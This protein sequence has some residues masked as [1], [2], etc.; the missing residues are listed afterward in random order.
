MTRSSPRTAFTGVPF[1]AMTVWLNPK[2]FC[3]AVL[4]RALLK[5]PQAQP[6]QSALVSV[7]GKLTTFTGTFES[8]VVSFPSSPP[9]FEPQ[10]FTAPPEVTAQA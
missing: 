7:H 3:L 9:E 10:H 5:A 4:K 6:K 1:G 2:G 8:V